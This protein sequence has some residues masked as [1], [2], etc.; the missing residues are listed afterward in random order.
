MNNRLNSLF[1]KV[2][3]SLLLIGLLGPLAACASKPAD[4]T[5]AP[6]PQGIIPLMPAT[7]LSPTPSPTAEPI[8]EPTPT[9]TPELAAEPVPVPSADPLPADYSLLDGSQ[10]N[11]GSYPNIVETDAGLFYI[12]AASK[13]EDGNNL[14]RI[15]PDGGNRTAIMTL[16]QGTRLYKN[17]NGNAIVFQPPNILYVKDSRIYFICQTREFV[18]D[19]G[20]DEFH[21]EYIC[22][23]D[24]NGKDLKVIEE[25]VK[26]G[27]Q[28]NFTVWRI[29]NYEN[30]IAYMKV[31][32]FRRPINTDGWEFIYEEG[33]ILRRK[34]DGSAATLVIADPDIY[35]FL[36]HNG[37][38]YFEK[39]RQNGIFRITIDGKGLTRVGDTDNFFHEFS[40]FTAVGDWIFYIGENKQTRE[41][42]LHRVKVDGSE[43]IEIVTQ[44]RPYTF[45]II[46]GRIFYNTIAVSKRSDDGSVMY[47]VNWNLRVMNLDGTGDRAIDNTIPASQPVDGLDSSTGAFPQIVRSG[48]ALFYING[49]W[50]TG[51]TLYGMRLDGTN[52]TALLTNQ[53]AFNLFKKLKKKAVRIDPQNILYVKGKR[54]YFT[55]MATEI[56]G[57]SNKDIMYIMSID[58]AMKNLKIERQLMDP[59]DQNQ[60]WTWYAA[61]SHVFMGTGKLVGY[62]P[63]IAQDGWKY[64]TKTEVNIYYKYL[65]KARSDGSD[66]ILLCNNPVDRFIVQGKWIYLEMVGTLGIYR[67]SADGGEPTMLGGVNNQDHKFSGFVVHGDWIYYNEQDSSGLYSLHKLKTDGSENVV[68]PTMYSPYSFQII[69]N[70]IFYNTMRNANAEA[71]WKLR[72]MN[73]A[74]TGDRAID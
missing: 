59:D 69:N 52:R 65:Y 7:T 67:M 56:M 35:R 68:I 66:E 44:L 53:Q 2:L 48:D 51:L 42:S 20:T 45:Q 23:I 29:E 8:V 22:S 54:I 58:F 9:P 31:R 57:D 15:D 73:L 19:R 10:S 55:C 43:A 1:R 38:E 39:L 72:V 28:Q 64:Y 16:E 3:A 50:N 61:N 71:S 70:R 60:F 37:W 41:Y 14:Y 63:A 17:I 32:G 21:G 27:D 46:N 24:F 26:P 11:Y 5:V 18:E 47:E 74:G 34:P 49:E 62:R 30:F 6:S 4:I 33:R 12:N 13:T 36:V 40:G 25:I